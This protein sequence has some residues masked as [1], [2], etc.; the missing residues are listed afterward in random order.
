MKISAGT[1][2]IYRNKILLCHPTNNSWVNSFSLPKG[3]VD[4]GETIIDAALRETR[5]E[6]G[7]TIGR[8]Q[9]SNLNKPLE[10]DYINKKNEL[11]KRVYVYIVKIDDLSEIGLKSEIIPTNQLQIAEVDWA[12]FLDIEE[13]NVK[14]FYRF[15]SLL[16]DFLHED[17]TV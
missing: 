4:E 16:T 6:V 15:K 11:F 14:I 3:G 7:I 12:G 13:A 10:F 5:E 2:I 9:I 8:T 17:Q 1:A